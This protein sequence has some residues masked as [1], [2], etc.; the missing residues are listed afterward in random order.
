MQFSTFYTNEKFSENDSNSFDFWSSTFKSNL[1]GWISW[2][3][4][5][6]ETS[7]LFYY[8]F[9]IF[10]SQ[11][12]NRFLFITVLIDQSKDFIYSFTQ[13]RH[14]HSIKTTHE[15]VVDLSTCGFI[16]WYWCF[17]S[18]IFLCWIFSLL[19]FLSP[20]KSAKSKLTWSFSNNQSDC[21]HFFQSSL[22]F[23]NLW[24][25]SMRSNEFPRTDTPFIPKWNCRRILINSRET[26]R[27]DAKD[28]SQWKHKR[29][30]MNV[31][32][33]NRAELSKE[34]FEQKIIFR[35]RIKGKT[36]K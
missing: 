25:D 14:S 16:S 23:M 34:H 6:D 20:E 28:F 24:S 22:I 3:D 31:C 33:V 32:I 18:A 4:K 29:C 7:R 35:F 36:E 15:I 10:I 30:V 11:Q 12:N 26:S 17:L 13:T 1:T 19:N 2:L 21:I 5:R 9:F 8:W 27:F